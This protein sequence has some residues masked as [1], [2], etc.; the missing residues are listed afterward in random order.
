[1]ESMKNK[2]EEFVFRVCKETFLSLWSYANPLGKDGKELCDILVV[3]EPEIVIFSVKEIKLMESGD[4]ETDWKRWNRRAIEESANQVY[5]AER[6]LKI[7]TH[8][9]KSDGSPGLK[10]WADHERRIHRVVVALGSKDKVP[11]VYG[12]LGKGFVHVLDEIS[13]G[14]IL[15]ELDTV[16]DFINYLSAKERFYMTGKE[17]PFLA[18]EENLLALYLHS[19]KKLPEDYTTVLIEGEL[20]D[21]FI[22][23]PEYLRKKGEDK[24]SYLWDDVI[25]D[26]AKAVLK[27]NLEFSMSPDNGEVILR[28][29]AREDRFS[30]RILGKS[31]AEFI[32]LSSEN[33]V[34]SRMLRSPS[35]VMYVLLALPHTI[36]RE[37]RRAELRSRCFI[38]RGLNL[39]CKTVIGIATEQSKP[40][41]GHSFDLYYLYLP[42]W[43]EEHQK[44]MEEIQ[45]E[46]GFFA[47]PV[48]TESHEDEYPQK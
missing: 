28:I 29:M 5:G 12:D 26:I 6:W 20:W 14:I 38:T 31:F 3:C 1:M 22:K 46:S 18:G 32:F 47:K 15:Q 35:G 44:R 19:G 40:G 34:R 4:I 42:E 11:M 45:K 41:V 24:I 17:T 25:E 23:K 43:K 33:K 9:I 27:G 39:D 13:F 2:A 48:S 36:D 10:L 7:A 16:S 8:I 30:R 37:Y 21:S